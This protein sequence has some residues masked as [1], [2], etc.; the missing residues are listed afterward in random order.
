[1]DEWG[2][3]L[4]FEQADIYNRDGRASIKVGKERIR[5]DVILPYRMVRASR[6]MALYERFEV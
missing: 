6:G 4:R 3:P 1:V 5:A 2:A